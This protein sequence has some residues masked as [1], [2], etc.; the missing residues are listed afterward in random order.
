MGRFKRPSEFFAWRLAG[1]RMRALAAILVAACL[2]GAATSAGRAH[3][4]PEPPAGQ[5]TRLP[6]GALPPLLGS[7]RP[8]DRKYCD[9]ELWVR[10]VPIIRQLRAGEVVVDEPAWARHTSSA[11]AGIASWISKC[12]LAGEAIRIRG[13]DSGDLL[14]V[15]SPATGYRATR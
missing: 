12:K 11:Q 13:D 2:A 8:D 9:E 15:Y 6:D 4:A 3:A 14:G 7:P 1:R 10:V 5:E